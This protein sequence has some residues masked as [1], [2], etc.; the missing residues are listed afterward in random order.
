MV[1]VASESGASCCNASSR[2]V[3]MR[4]NCAL[5]AINGYGSLASSMSRIASPTEFRSFWMRSSCSESLR[6]RSTISLC[7]LRN[8]AN[9]TV[10]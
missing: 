7:N 4:S 1:G 8:P 6:L 5:H 2:S 10:M 9:C 3:R